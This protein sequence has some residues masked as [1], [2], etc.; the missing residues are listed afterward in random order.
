MFK[1][2]T[3]KK[4]LYYDKVI[5]LYRDEHLGVGRISRVLPLSMATISIWIRNFVTDNPQDRRPRML[6][7]NRKQAPKSSR[8]AASTPAGTAST[9]VEA[10][11]KELKEMRRKLADAELK[12]AIYDEMIN[13]AEQKF[14]IAIRKKAGTK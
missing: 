9:D 3:E 14:N 6:K 7:R 5:H 10:L 1:Y 12:A 4:R 2:S 13:V 11:R 8:S